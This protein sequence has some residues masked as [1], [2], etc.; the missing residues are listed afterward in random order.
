MILA[1]EPGVSGQITLTEG[2]DG[3]L[4]EGQVH[5]LTPGKHGF[6]VHA[7]GDISKGCTS[8]GGHYNPHNVCTPDC[9]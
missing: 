6:H 2:A 8:T 5:G 3:L 7:L 9:Q 4:L 1:G